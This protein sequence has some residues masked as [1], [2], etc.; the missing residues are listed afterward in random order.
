M[1]QNQALNLNWTEVDSSNVAAVGHVEDKEVLLV[2]FKNGG[3]YSYKDADHD[4]FV[5]I[6]HAESVGKYLNQ[7]VKAM[8]LSYMRWD[9]E[10][11]LIEHI[12][13]L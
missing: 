8:G 3:L 5:S 10:A 7:H 9:S 13:S 4:L 1:P 12:S 6:I 11:E 2:K